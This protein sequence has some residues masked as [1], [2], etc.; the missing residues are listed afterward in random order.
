VLDRVGVLKDILPASP[1]SA[2]NVS[3]ARVRHH[4]TANPPC[5]DLK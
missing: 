2:S 5:V 4:L 1:D 3:D